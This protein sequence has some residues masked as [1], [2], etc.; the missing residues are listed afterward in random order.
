MR[1]A[2]PPGLGVSELPKKMKYRTVYSDGTPAVTLGYDSVGRLTAAANGTD[3][4]TWVYDIAGQLSSEASTFNSSTVAYTYDN[5]GSRATLSLN[6]TQFLA[7]GYD[8]V[9]RLTSITQ[10]SNVFG[11]GYDNADRRNSLAYPNGVTTAY[12][13]DTLNRLTNLDATIG[14]GTITQ[15][16][17]TYDNAS[18]RLTKTSPDY[19]E[20]YTYDS[21]YRLTQAVRTNS[22]GTN[23]WVWTYDAMGNRLTN[24]LDDTVTS[25]TYNNL[26]QIQT[27]VGGGPLVVRGHL[28]KAGTATVNGAPAQMTAGNVFQ[29]TINTTPGTNTFTVVATD[30]SGNQTTQAYQVTLSGTS[31]TYTED[32]DGN[33]TQKVEGSNTYVYSWDANNRLKS[34]TQNGT[35]IASFAYDAIGRRVQKVAAGL[36]TTFLYAGPN[37]LQQTTGGT[38]QKFVHGPGIDEPLASVPSSGGLTFYHADALGSVAKNSNSSGSITF[39]YQYDPWGNIQTG[40][41]QGGFS[42]TGREWDPETGLYYY[43]A[44]YYDPKMGRF[45]RQDPI[46]FRGGLNFYAYAGDNPVNLGDPLGTT[47]MSNTR[48][49][50]GW[51][52]GALPSQ[53][54][55]PP[56]SVETQ[57][58]MTSPGSQMLRALFRAAHCNNIGPVYFGTGQA[59]ATTL[60]TPCSTAAQV[61]GFQGFARLA[62]KCDAE[63]TIVNVAGANSFFYHVLPNSPFASGPMNNVTQVF[64]WKEPSPCGCSCP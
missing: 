55:Y 45:I 13:F 15:W 63:Y 7:Y 53:N 14:S 28:N 5:N 24:Q 26:N 47:C 27:G 11:L 41:S 31:D 40:S 36:T 49:L 39:T 46:G 33:L 34:I 22:G 4:L 19:S 16:G 51:L 9:S 20:T 2:E 8:D 62:D 25:S 58:M 54:F 48:F 64:S 10:G 42:F 59:A 57:E 29:S 44:R 1:N 50:F 6:G 30:V 35:P 21:L 61:G 60:V 23:H 52:F 17:Y 43:R 3:S 38:V 18:N 12:T 56:D 37:I 32:A